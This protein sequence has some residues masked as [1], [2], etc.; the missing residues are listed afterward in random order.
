MQDLVIRGAVVVDG[1]GNEPVSADVAV[2]RAVTNDVPVLSVLA[3]GSMSRAVPVAIS[4][5]KPIAREKRADV[6]AGTSLR[7]RWCV[8]MRTGISSR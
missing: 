6:E 8:L 4:A 3:A 2:K 5:A 1:L 7:R